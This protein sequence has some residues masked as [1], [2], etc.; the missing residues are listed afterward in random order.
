MIEKDYIR[1]MNDG[2]IAPLQRWEG[3]REDLAERRQGKED[4]NFCLI[5]FLLIYPTV[6]VQVS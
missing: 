3:G 6:C 2:M 5:M 1:G 4:D